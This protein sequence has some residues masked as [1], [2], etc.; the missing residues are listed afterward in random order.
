MKVV[1]D[2]DY[3]SPIEKDFARQLMNGADMDDSVLDA[4]IESPVI[5]SKQK[6]MAKQYFQERQKPK[7]VKFKQR[8]YDKDI[9]LVSPRMRFHGD[10]DF[11]LRSIDTARD[12][13][14]HFH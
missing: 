1:E 8:R 4:I 7:R 11:R 2:S 13:S 10:F 9:Q 3:F 5:S 6:E 14:N 12:I